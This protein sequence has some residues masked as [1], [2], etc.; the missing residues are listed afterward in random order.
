M[1]RILGFHCCGPGSISGWGTEIPQAI[2]CSQK[3][4]KKDTN[5]LPGIAAKAREMKR[6]KRNAAAMSEGFIFSD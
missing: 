6:K 2:Q 1:V 4:K 3:E 5:L